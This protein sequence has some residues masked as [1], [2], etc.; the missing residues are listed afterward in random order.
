[1]R[2]FLLF[3][4]ACFLRTPP[5]KP[6]AKP[7]EGGSKPGVSATWERS[8]T[9]ILVL[10]LDDIGPNGVRA[11]D[12]VEDQP[13]TPTID[14][15]ARDGVLFHNAYSYPVC[16]AARAALLTGRYARRTGMGDALMLDDPERLPHAEVTI[17]EMLDRAGRS[18]AS[19]A[20]GKWHLAGKGAAGWKRDALDQGFDSHRGSPANILSYQTG[21]VDATYS[22]YEKLDNGTLGISKTYATTETVDDTLKA[23]R[24]MPEPWFTWVSF[25]APH[26][27]FHVP[28]GPL[29]KTGVAE[30]DSRTLKYRAMITAMD[31]EIGR[32]LD[33]LD[34]AVRDRTMVFVIG[35]NGG[36]P[37]VLPDPLDG[38]QAKFTLY[39]GGTNVPFIVAGAGVRA[40]GEE[41]KA[42]VHVVDLF[43]TVAELARVDTP[44]NLDGFSLMPLLADPKAAW[45]R[46][47][48]F[49][50]RFRP[51]GP[52]PYDEEYVA[53]RDKRYKLMEVRKKGE[54]T[55]RHLFDLRGKVVDGEPL[56]DLDA[57]A[58]AA[59]KRL[60]LALKGYEALPYEGP[61]L[62]R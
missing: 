5:S 46:E 23:I 36:P 7:D 29:N 12:E 56:T 24:Q 28:P 20:V 51:V 22:H 57:D 39:E 19:A 18:Y 25:N 27:P 42:L 26:D 17:P 4:L 40:R 37:G 30:S 1:M 35:D 3:T 45:R 41:S 60:E 21:L 33:S 43:P 52:G 53:V 8:A 59:Q 34:P 62:L 49:T 15:L 61:E 11:Y 16:S 32:L 55:Q 13:K 2:L 58:R 10:V 38:R 9:N 54:P 6:A 44:R 14:K 50:E 31:L 47:V 48:L